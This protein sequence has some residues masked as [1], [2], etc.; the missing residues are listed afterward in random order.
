MKKT[1]LICA[2]LLMCFGL[3]AAAQRDQRGQRG[4]EDQKERLEKRAK[5]LAKQL[6]LDDATTAWFT[7]IYIEMQDSLTS[8]RLQVRRATRQDE[9][10]KKLED[11]NEEESAERLAA[12]FAL[13]ERELAIKRGYA[14]RMSERLTAN[15]VLRVFTMP[16]RQAPQGARSGGFPG[17]GFPPAAASKRSGGFQ[18]SPSWRITSVRPTLSHTFFIDFGRGYGPMGLSRPHGATVL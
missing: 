10:N 6:K 7:P 1:L 17:G 11:L 12:Q 2:V 15:Q 8:V 4:Q 16:Q 3:N 18:A 9:G 14:V 13:T 5:Q